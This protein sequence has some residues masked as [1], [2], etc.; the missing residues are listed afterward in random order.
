[1]QTGIYGKL[2]ITSRSKVFENQKHSIRYF[3]WLR[4]QHWVPTT[5]KSWHQVYTLVISVWSLYVIQMFEAISL[6][7]KM[8]STFNPKVNSNL[9]PVGKVRGWRRD[10]VSLA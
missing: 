5:G 9:M 4:D 1:M 8:I 10:M 2:K 6:H 3:N 7:A